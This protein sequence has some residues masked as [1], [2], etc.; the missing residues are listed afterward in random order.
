MEELKRAAAHRAVEFVSDGMVVGLGSGTTAYHATLRIAELL[1]NGQLRDIVAV[2][3][4]EETSRL[5]RK[6]GIPL[7]S[8]DEH[9]SLDLTIDGA[10]EVDPQLNVIKGRHGYLLRE[11]IVAAASRCEIIVVDESK[12][13]E[14]LGSRS[15]V[16]VEVVPFGWRVTQV[17]LACTGART[18]LRL[19]QGQPY[20]TDEG[21]FLI[22][23]VYE[24][25]IASPRELEARVRA[26]PGV[27]DSGLF[28]GLVD[29]VVVAS[30]SG[31]DILRR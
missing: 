22:D 19:E 9:V 30:H 2:P 31:V 11:K 10:D 1:H 18:A 23:C 24:G 4:S 26:I 6:H 13:V 27:V 5:A 17:A 7:T 14:Q 12:L 3:T 15:P 16:P 25:G 21:H 28:L 8:L 29:M 20:R